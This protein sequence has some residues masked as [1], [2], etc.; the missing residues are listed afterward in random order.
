[1]QFDRLIDSCSP[2]DAEQSEGDLVSVG[3]PRC[4]S[5]MASYGRNESERGAEVEMDALVFLQIMKHC[6]RGVLVAGL[7][8]RAIFETEFDTESDTESSL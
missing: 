2:P 1:M 7:R 4:L 8:G 6:R 3:C 5:R